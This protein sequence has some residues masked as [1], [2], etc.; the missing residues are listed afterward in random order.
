MTPDQLAAAIRHTVV[1]AVERGDLALS[2]DQVPA[3][4][5]VDRPKNP[6]HGDYATNIALQLAKPAGSNPRVVAALLAGLLLEV[7][8]IA[9]VAVAGPGFLNVTLDTASLGEIARNV[10]TARSLSSSLLS[11]PRRSRSRSRS[12]PT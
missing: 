8:G 5:T 10:V 9:A 7:E 1:A 2:P 3:T 6:E 11:S 4:V 12:S